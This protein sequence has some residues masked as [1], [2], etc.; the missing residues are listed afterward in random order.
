MSPIM[1]FK[2]IHIMVNILKNNFAKKMAVKFM[3]ELIATHA[4]L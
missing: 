4:S 3:P 2:C 1:A